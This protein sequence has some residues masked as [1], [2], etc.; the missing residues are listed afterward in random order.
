[1]SIILEPDAVGHDLVEAE[2]KLHGAPA[3]RKQ[4][5]GIQERFAAG[6]A[7][8]SNAKLGGL[9]QKAQ[10]RRNRQPIGPFDGHATMR[11]SEI[12]LVG[13]GKRQVIGAEGPSSV[14]GSG[15]RAEW[16]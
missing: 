3:Q 2:A 13:A 1:M 12:A 10:G 16:L 6:E 14:R 11:A 5:F 8:D 7:K 15:V 9:F 4:E